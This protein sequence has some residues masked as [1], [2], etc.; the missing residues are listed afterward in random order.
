M[1]I[2]GHEELTRRVVEWIESTPL[3]PQTRLDGADK[4]LVGMAVAATVNI[5]AENLMRAVAEK[6]SGGKIP[7]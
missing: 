2:E 6:S 5:M 4:M 1:S 7:G 3:G